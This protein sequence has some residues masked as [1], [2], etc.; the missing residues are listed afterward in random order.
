[1]ETGSTMISLGSAS[2][3]DSNSPLA[4]ASFES[5][6]GVSFMGGRYDWILVGPVTDVSGGHASVMGYR[7]NVDDSDGVAAAAESGKMV[8][9]AARPEGKSAA[10]FVT[11]ED[12]VAGSTEVVVSGK[13]ER[14][15]SSVAKLV[16]TNG[17]K[18]DFSD[19]SNASE[20]P[21]IQIGDLIYVQGHLY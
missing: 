4:K 14:V 10:V 15:D 13:V 21:S 8:A 16:L 19:L 9:V 2:V 5:T 12:F 18:V 17:V 6:P 3:A 20:M 11:D 1:M 7:F